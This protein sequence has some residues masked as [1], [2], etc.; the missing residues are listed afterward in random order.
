VLSSLRTVLD[1]AFVLPR[2]TEVLSDAESVEVF[3]VVEYQDDDVDA[4]HPARA[5]P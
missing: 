3:P 1:R 5:E 4:S 2:E